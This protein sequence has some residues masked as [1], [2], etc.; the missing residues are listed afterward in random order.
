[1]DLIFIQDGGCFLTACK[2]EGEGGGIF[3]EVPVCPI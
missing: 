3:F 2:G 1:M